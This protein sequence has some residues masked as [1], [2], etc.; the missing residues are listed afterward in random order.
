MTQDEISIQLLYKDV[1]DFH[2]ELESS[3]TAMRKGVI[4]EGRI[5]AAVSAPFASFSGIYNYPTI[6][7]RAAA[8]WHGIANNHGFNDGNK[9][10]ATHSMLVYLGLNGIDL[11]YEQKELSDM[12]VLI[13]SGSNKISREEIA[14]WI[15]D[16]AFYV[17]DEGE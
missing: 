13:G 5:E 10:T 2:F 8:L 4:D 17:D 6:F 7:D 1:I 9:R 3:G 14:N 16:R 15:E 11:D 12:A